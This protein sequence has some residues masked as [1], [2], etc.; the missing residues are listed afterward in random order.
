MGILGNVL[1]S[2]FG[3][4][5][6]DSGEREAIAALARGWEA[7]RA[8]FFRDAENI[9]SVILAHGEV[10]NELRGD[11]WQLRG[12]ARGSVGDLEGA[13]EDYKHALQIMPGLKSCLLEQGRILHELNRFEDALEVAERIIQLD[14]Q[15]AVAHNNRGLMLRELA[16]HGEAEV[17]LRHALEI[18]GDFYDARANLA[19]VLIERGRLQEAEVELLKV[20]VE[21]PKHRDARWNRAIL[22]LLIGNFA[23]GWK[24]Y[25]SRLESE[26][27]SSRRPYKYPEWD[28]GDLEK[29]ALLIY[30]EQ[31]LGDE[32]LFASCYQDTIGRAGRCIIE[33]EPRLERL[34]AR[35]FPSAHIVGSKF[36][37]TPDWIKEETVISAQIPAGS[38]PRFFR[39]RRE[40]FP[41][42]D[43]Y[44][45]VD[46]DAVTYWRARLETLGS[47]LKIGVSWN[48]GTP[49][50]RNATR[51]IPL[52]AWL[53][54]LRT[55]NTHFVSL[56]Y[57]NCTAE[58]ADFTL[59]SGLPLHH[60]PEAIDDY[61]KT[62][63]LVSALD[64]V[65]SVTTAIVHLSGALGRKVWVLV[66]A[67]PEWRYLCSGDRM[68][69]YPSAKLFRQS[70]IG[71]WTEV[72]CEVGTALRSHVHLRLSGP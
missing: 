35:S 45:R 52:H 16:R 18:N 10:R 27:A 51:S 46:S 13:L 47:G 15:N 38:L 6:R 56:Q 7:Y 69:W 48:G 42:H 30:G 43:G 62:A 54:V 21:F 40:D 68:P 28:G 23:E 50:T 57:G 36:Q 19:L 49:R 55:P 72:M 5:T 60:W 4:R 29:G 44:L 9:A 31:G 33:C 14:P 34:F 37:P 25:G 11:A 8:G 41:A 58:I 66:P 64:L 20:L 26:E 53:P 65:I 67:N 3:G 63:A 1:R 71:E 12:F 61:D 24:D 17:A 22:N 39:N 59:H 32:L 70:K 2:L